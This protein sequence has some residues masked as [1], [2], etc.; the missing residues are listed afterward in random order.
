MDFD[1]NLIH[2]CPFCDVFLSSKFKG[3]VYPKNFR[4]VSKSNFVIVVSKDKV[5]MVIVR[6]HIGTISNEIW[7]KILQEAKELYGSRCKLELNPI[8]GHSHWHAKILRR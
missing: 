7:G 6:D 3:L 2:G 8:L 1:H 4:D 5:P